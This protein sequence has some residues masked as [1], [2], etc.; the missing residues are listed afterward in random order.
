MRLKRALRS[1]LFV[2]IG[3]FA[4]TRFAPQALAFPYSATIGSTR[5][6]SEQPIAVGQIAT[7]LSRS[8]AKLRKSELYG[9]HYGKAIY[10]TQGG[11]RWSALALRDF[12]AF[13]L[14]FPI[15]EAIIVNRS[16][17][18]DDAVMNGAEIAGRRS[19]SGV[20][21]H[22]R[23]HG[24]IRA[25]FGLL[26]GGRYPNWLIEGYCDAVAEES[27]LSDAQAHQLINAHTSVP[28]LEYYEGRKR[29]ERELAGSTVAALFGK[30]QQS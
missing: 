6:Y 3:M 5:I 2:L 7:I 19:L 4:L 24:L 29:V 20:I 26:A 27:S 25:K 30:Y 10:L 15:S 13:A 23:T 14:S 18:P 11:W 16:S 12:D 21:A 28:A 22:E 9:D 1:V 8:D 17:L